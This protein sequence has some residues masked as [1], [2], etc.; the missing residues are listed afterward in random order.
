MTAT[1]ITLSVI[2]A[3]LLI[4]FTVWVVVFLGHIVW[5]ILMALLGSQYTSSRKISSS[6][7]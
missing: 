3:L 2:V 1:L 5:G 7:K 6:A 4:M